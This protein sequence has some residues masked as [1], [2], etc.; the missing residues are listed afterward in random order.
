MTHHFSRRT[1]LRGVGVSM[2]L[3]WMESLSVWGDQIAQPAGQVDE[4]V[5]TD[6]LRE[7]LRRRRH[8]LDGTAS[9]QRSEQI[10]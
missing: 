3:P 6:G 10:H 7:V 5:G 4:P 9:G 2:A 1:F 8:G